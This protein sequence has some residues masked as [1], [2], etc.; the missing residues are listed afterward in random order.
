MSSLFLLALIAFV[1]VYGVC[2]ADQSVTITSFSVGGRVT[3]DVGAVKAGAP[4]VATATFSDATNHSSNFGVLEIQTSST[5]SDNDQMFAAGFAEG[6]LTA[7]RIFQ[8]YNNMMCQVD[9]S[10]SVPVELSN[11][12]VE[13]DAW[14]RRQVAANP[15]D[16][17]WMHIGSLQSQLGGVEKGY[18]ESA[19]GSTNPLSPWA[20][21]MINGM[22]DLFDII[23]AV[24]PSARPNFNKM[25]YHQA[26]SYLTR[27]GHCSALIKLLDD[28]SDIYVGHNA[29]FVYS[30]MLRIY[31]TYRFSLSNKDSHATVTSFSSYPG[32]LNSLDDFYMMAGSDLI[33]TQTTNNIFNSSLWDLVVPQSLL[34]RC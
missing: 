23:P 2:A 30:S 28:M 33:M 9:C 13:Q 3:Y 19:F 18:S 8:H 15:T 26:R 31:K 7:E 29:W 5:A 34:G 24:T 10:G 4:Y 6:Y 25:T 20:F 1:V 17:F 22:G 12:F 16:S 32:S 27:V 14:A 11:F 21:T